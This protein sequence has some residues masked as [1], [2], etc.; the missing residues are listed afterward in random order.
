[1]RGEQQFM[2]SFDM[3]AAEQKYKLKP[4][5]VVIFLSAR[6]QTKYEPV[7]QVFVIKVC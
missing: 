1:M 7:W 3:K 5:S 6:Y 2:H 4:G